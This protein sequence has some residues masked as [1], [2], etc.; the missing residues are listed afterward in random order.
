MSRAKRR[1]AHLKIAASAV[2]ILLAL[3]LLGYTLFT[4]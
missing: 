4:L 1:M 2:Y 3:G